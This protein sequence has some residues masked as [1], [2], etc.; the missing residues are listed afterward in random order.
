MFKTLTLA[1]AAIAAT[2][3]M[4]T[5]DSYISDLVSEQDRD[6]IVELGTVRAAADGVVEIYS[7]H[8]GEI[9]ALIGSE[10]V[11]AG[12]NTDVDI[13]IQRTGLDAIALLKV[14]GQVVDSQELDF[15]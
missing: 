9:G 13:S 15:D 1:A 6:T 2:A 10:N 3:T 7:F 11:H 12:A 4:A 5:A 14:N 8:A